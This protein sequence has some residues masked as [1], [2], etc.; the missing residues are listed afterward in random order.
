VSYILALLANLKVTTL[1]EKERK[2]KEILDLVAGET[3]LRS[4]RELIEKF[5]IENLPLIQSE[6]IEED[7]NSFMDAEKL[8]AFN[9]FVED[10]KLNADKLKKLTEDYIF[11]QRTPTKQ[12]VV[13]VLE[14]QPSIMQRSSIGDIILNKFMNFVNTFFND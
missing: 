8:K 11:T 10:E 12:E 6:N 3:K 14:N 13:D 4:K 2:Q 7:Y 1:E 9:K 5:I